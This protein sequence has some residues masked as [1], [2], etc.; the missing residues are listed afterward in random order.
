MLSKAKS[1]AMQEYGISKEEADELIDPSTALLMYQGGVGGLDPKTLRNGYSYYK[2]ARQ[3]GDIGADTQFERDMVATAGTD[4]LESAWMA[5]PIGQLASKYKTVG[6]AIAG[7]GIGFAL[8]EA[9][10][11]GLEGSAIGAGIGAVAA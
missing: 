1:V 6:R 9:S 5:L 7:G 3:L 11:F 4:L 8:G 10:G 2:A